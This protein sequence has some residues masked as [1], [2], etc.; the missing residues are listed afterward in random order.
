MHGSK[1]GG[2]IESFITFAY[3]VCVQFKSFRIAVARFVNTQLCN[4]NNRAWELD[5]E[6]VHVGVLQRGFLLC[7]CMQQ[8]TMCF[9]IMIWL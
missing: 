3:I 5:H 8:H 6:Y 2:S 4:I 7:M 1:L 9:L